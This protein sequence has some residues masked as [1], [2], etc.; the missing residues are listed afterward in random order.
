MVG[1]GDEKMKFT[2]LT[3]ENLPEP[4]K[5]V[6]IK[7]VKENRIYLGHRQ[8]KPYI[9]NED[10]SRDCYWIANPQHNMLWCEGYELKFYNS[11]SDVTVDSWADLDL[12]NA[13]AQST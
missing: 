2:K 4:N 7:R 5:L 10:P 12:P 8:D 3:A 1:R 9:V 6:W 13:N 11:F